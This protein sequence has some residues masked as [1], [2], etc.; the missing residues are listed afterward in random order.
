[1]SFSWQEVSAGH[2]ETLSILS[3]LRENIDYIDNNYACSSH[4]S[5]AYSTKYSSVLSS[6]DA[7]AL[8]SKYISVCGSHLTVWINPWNHGRVQGC[9]G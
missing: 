7:S 8:S 1:M 5:S 2:I 3:E 6:N 9:G 4:N